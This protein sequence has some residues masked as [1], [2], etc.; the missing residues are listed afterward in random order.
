MSEI[1]SLDGILLKMLIISARISDDPLMYRNTQT[2]LM[3]SHGLSTPGFRRRPSAMG[4][5]AFHLF[6]S[7]V[8]LS[9]DKVLGR[10]CLHD[11]II[12]GKQVKMSVFASRL[13][14]DGSAHRPAH[15]IGILEK[16]SNCHRQVPRAGC[17]RCLSPDCS[18]RARVATCMVISAIYKRLGA[19]HRTLRLRRIQRKGASSFDI[20]LLLDKPMIVC[21]S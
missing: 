9:D 19:M 21:W 3:D 14:H 17:Q 11:L 5:T 10:S 8:L 7:C 15:H 20:A 18:T 2:N 16:L 6:I 4:N 12:K 13:A 1:P